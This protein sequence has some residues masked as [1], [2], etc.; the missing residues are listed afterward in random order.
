M[1]RMKCNT[2]E[3]LFWIFWLIFTAIAIISLYFS[4][5]KKEVS[6]IDYFYNSYSEKGR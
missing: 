5:P 4:A 2:K 3:P 6:G 1:R